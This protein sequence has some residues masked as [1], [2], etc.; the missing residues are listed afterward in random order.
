MAPPDRPAPWAPPDELID[1]LAE[2]LLAQAEEAT[3]GPLATEPPAPSI[4]DIQ[5]S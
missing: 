2:L 1:S 4:S 5:S 3:L